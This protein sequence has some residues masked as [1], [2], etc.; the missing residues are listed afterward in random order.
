MVVTRSA[1][2]KGGP[3]RGTVTKAF[4]W[5]RHRLYGRPRRA[6][7]GRMFQAGAR[8]PKTCMVLLAVFASAGSDFEYQDGL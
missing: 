5:L 4:D 8:T 2:L 1:L 7:E 6:E 3:R